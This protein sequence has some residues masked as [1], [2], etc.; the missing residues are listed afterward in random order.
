MSTLVDILINP[1][2]LRFSYHNKELVYMFASNP[3]QQLDEME[4]LMGVTTDDGPIFDTNVGFL[5]VATTTLIR[6]EKTILID[7][8]NYHIGFYSILKR[9]LAS[10]NLTYE[11]ID[12]IAT[13]HTH[14]DHAASIVHFRNKPWVIGNKEFDDMEAIE[15]K[16][17][18]EAK[19]SMMGEI[20]EISDKKET[21]IIENVYAITTPGHTNGHIS[22]VVKS[23]NGTILIAGDQTM[24]KE[25]YCHRNFSR[26][27]PEENLKQLNASLDKAKSYNPDLI[28]PGHDRSFKPIK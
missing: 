26:W 10:K 5:P 4:K 21:K 9:A 20:I 6:G 12:I 22:F 24:T 23:D 17:I 2:T 3:E 18:V 16:E 7:P 27:Y 14:S 28:I 11:D 8:G 19:K 13:T 25:E 15:G 1:V